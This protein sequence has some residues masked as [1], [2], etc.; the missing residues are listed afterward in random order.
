[1]C[2][3]R[4]VGV[5]NEILVSPVVALCA[6]HTWTTGAVFGVPCSLRRGSRSY[7][8][9]VADGFPARSEQRRPPPN[10]LARCMASA[11]S[12][13]HLPA[14]P[15]RRTDAAGRM[16]GGGRRVRVQCGTGGWCGTC[17]ARAG[18]AARFSNQMCAHCSALDPTRLTSVP[19]PRVAPPAAHISGTAPVCG[20]TRALL[21]V[22]VRQSSRPNLCA[23]P[24][25]VV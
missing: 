9:A 12:M 13:L 3:N 19:S 15:P 14:D 7:A 11:R 6:A 21:G 23:L 8:R 22:V 4:N 25:G 1:M 24:G 20:A 17:A 10:T 5:R 16:H 2:L 18:G